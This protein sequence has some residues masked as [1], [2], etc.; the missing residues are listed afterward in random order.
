[1]L[2]ELRT[3]TESRADLAE[4]DAQL[5]E[6]AFIARVVDRLCFWI[7]LSVMLVLTLAIMVSA[8]HH[9]R[10]LIPPPPGRGGHAEGGLAMFWI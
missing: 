4:E 5:A 3:I 7:F 10:S 1:M 6:W 2:R 9:L 8:P